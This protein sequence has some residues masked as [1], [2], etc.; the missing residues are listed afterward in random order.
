[1]NKAELIQNLIQSDFDGVKMYRINHQGKRGYCTAEPFKIYSGLTGALSAA[2]FKG[3]Q[4][5]KRLEGWRN[6][7]QQQLGFEGQE[8]YLNSMADFG[9]LVHQALVRIQQQG[10]LVW[11]DEQ[12]YARE[13]FTGSCKENGIN[14]SDAVLEAQI[15]DYCKA[16]A[17]IMQWVYDNITT[18]HAIECMAKDDALM[19]A[20]PLD[21]VC[22]IKTK[23][24]DVL[25]NINIKTSKQITGHHR[26]QV[27][28]ERYL[29]NQTYP[30]MMLAAT[31]VMRPKDYSLKKGVPT[32]E[33]ELIKQEEE[34]EIL[35]DTLSRLIL[36]R[37][38]PQNTYL[39]FPTTVYR[40]A[41]ETKA[42]EL[43]RIEAT[44]IE[45]TLNY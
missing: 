33:M 32:Y 29:W 41:G 11:S 45:Q 9:T 27:V 18:I 12:D 19:I 30:G 39:T 31:G 16:A 5:A 23:A 15:F 6:K 43:P 2:T 36:C 37:G 24:G 34:N 13:F 42:G 44:P 17:S 22:T 28:I 3:N 26:E 8:A 10:K 7:M 4:D 40:F 35:N 14:I 1:M 21:V 38:N 20:T 25:T